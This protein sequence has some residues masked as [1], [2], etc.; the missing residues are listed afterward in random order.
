MSSVRVIATCT[1]PRSRRSSSAL[2]TLD[3]ARNG[4]IS[5]RITSA[6]ALKRCYAV[7]ISNAFVG[8]CSYQSLCRGNV[9]LAT[10][11]KDNSL[12]EGGPAKVVDVIER[13]AGFD[14]C[15]HHRLNV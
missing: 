5:Q 3:P 14:Q 15:L 9:P 11:A 7:A 2:S 8:T 10:I 13:R 12:Y 1:K 6:A 4:I